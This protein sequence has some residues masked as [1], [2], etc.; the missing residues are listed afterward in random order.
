MAVPIF[1]IL[2]RGELQRK[3]EANYM[4]SRHEN[5]YESGWVYAKY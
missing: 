4:K 1:K 5:S 2:E 3:S